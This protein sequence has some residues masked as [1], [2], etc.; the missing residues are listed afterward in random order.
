LVITKSQVSDFGSPLYSFTESDPVFMAA[1]TSLAYQPIGS[2]LTTYNS[3][4]ALAVFSGVS[5]T[6]ATT[7]NLIV[8]SIT[9]SWLSTNASGLV[10]ATTAPQTFIT[11]GTANDYY[12]GDKT[13]AATSTLR[14]TKSQITDFGTYEN[15]LTFTYPLQRTVDAISLAF[16]TTTSNT[17]A[18]TQTFSTV[19]STALQVNGN[20]TTTGNLSVGNFT[21]N[22][23]NFTDLTGTGLVN[24]G[25]ALTHS[26]A[27]G[28]SHIPATGA[29][30]Q[31]LQYT[32][33]GTAKWI[34]LS[35]QASIADGG[36]LTVSDMTCTDCL[37]ATEIEDIYVLNTSDT[38]SGSLAV[39]TTLS[40]GTSTLTNLIVTNLTTSTFAGGL[41]VGTSQFVVQQATG[42]VGIGT[43]S[44]NSLRK[45]TIEGTGNTA[46]VLFNDTTDNSAFYAGV[47]NAYGGNFAID[48][49]GVAN[50]LTI[51]KGTGFVGLG[52]TVPTA[53]LDVFTASP[54]IIA[55]FSA[56]TPAN[57]N[58]SWMKFNSGTAGATA[59]GYVGMAHNGSGLD[60][61]FTGEI[62]DSFGIRGETALQLGVGATPYINLTGGNVGIG[63]TGP[64]AKLDV[65][66]GAVIF[67]NAYSAS[68]PDLSTTSING[69]IRALSGAGSAWGFLRLSAG[70]AN[71]ISTQSAIDIQG[72]GTNDSQII[73]MLTAGTERMRINSTGNVGI[74]T[75]TPAQKLDVYGNANFGT[76][77]AATDSIIDFSAAGVTKFS[78]GYDVSTGLFTLT[79]S[80]SL[81]TNNI[82]VISSSTGNV[83][84]NS[85]TASTTSKFVV[86]NSA[87]VW[88]SFSS[89]GTWINGSDVRLKKDIATLDGSLQKVL[90]LRPVR[91][92]W[93]GQSDMG[94]STGGNIGFIAQ[95][96]DQ[97]IPE[98]VSHDSEYLG[99]SYGSFAPILAGAIQEQQAQI[100]VLKAQISSSTVLTVNQTASPQSTLAVT[101]QDPYF[102][103]LRVAGASTFYGTI[104]VIGEAGFQSKVT[105]EKEVEFNDHLLVDQDTAGTA[106]IAAG[107]TSTEVV[108]VKPYGLMPRVVATLKSS[109][110]PVFAQYAIADQTSSTFKIILEQPAIAD[111]YFNWIALASKDREGQ[112]AG[113]QAIAGCTDSAA[114]NYN[115]QATEND[116]SCTYET[117]T[118]PAEPPPAAPPTEEPA[119]PAPVLGCLDN[120]ATN[121]D[122]LATQ[123]NGTCTY[124]PV[125]PPAEPP[126]T[127]PVEPSPTEPVP[128]EPPPSEPVPT[129]P[130]PII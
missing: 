97:I 73:R 81:G 18:G 103:T 88:G 77:A 35:G 128:T 47:F 119:P 27:N 102:N 117:V 28:Y 44:P 90:G 123:D 31:L 58:G 33:A 84:I 126:V 5:S 83:A 4:T 85:A 89:G 26:T 43:T 3:S 72:Y 80:T 15:P 101:D 91:Y 127:P 122:P 51:A 108:F 45:L 12:R 36:V 113:V 9:N 42:N 19:S 121:Y 11:A 38:M 22:G 49:N 115:D 66:S 10:V 25:G 104:N 48:E 67:S 37:N 98:V 52:K 21:I 64:L 8:T 76:G 57:G 1:S 62:N 24:T 6:N 69:E 70:G 2:Y 99:L 105:F 16:G 110:T 14:L 46:A 40:A 7:T 20:A 114:L 17:W 124:K 39:G 23:E 30:A 92:N 60:S 78:M 55:A 34:T 130:P 65:N 13:W 120:T 112:V 50:W 32:S 116:G 63:T 71:A 107:A 61:I 86:Y 106:I 96:V 93:I 79:T 118:P 56:T 68:L 53:K 41:T 87:A 111:I 74:G 54:G 125:T 82:L 129:E 75:T 109:G 95:E 100:E 94:T 59:R 29:S